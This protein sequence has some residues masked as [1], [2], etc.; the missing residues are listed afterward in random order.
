MIYGGHFDPDEKRKRVNELQE[1]ME[2]PDFWNDKRQSEIV[3]SEFNDL[4]NLL[5]KTNELKSEIEFHCESLKEA[6]ENDEA[7]M[8]AID[9][10]NLISENLELVQ[11][12][13]KLAIGQIC[14]IECMLDG[15]KKRVIK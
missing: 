1:M 11:G 10:M 7:M 9:E 5:E 2:K 12:G 8:F 3:I 14:F 6:S 4:K 15:V 13:L